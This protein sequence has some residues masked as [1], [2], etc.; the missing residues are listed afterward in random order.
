MKEQHLCTLQFYTHAFY[1][2]KTSWSHLPKLTTE[3]LFTMIFVFTP[4][5]WP[6]PQPRAPYVD[7]TFENERMILGRGH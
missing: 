1:Q 4:P 3:E 5:K 2:P 7:I 6:I